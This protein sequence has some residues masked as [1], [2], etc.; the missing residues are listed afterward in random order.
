MK[1]TILVMLAVTV[2]D[3]QSLYNAAF[4]DALQ[5]SGTSVDGVEELLGTREEPNIAECVRWLADPGVSW[6]GTTIEGSE[7]E[8]ITG[9][10]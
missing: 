6:P 2:E 8:H 5:T 9:G 1:H 3:P 4:N 10:A 7:V